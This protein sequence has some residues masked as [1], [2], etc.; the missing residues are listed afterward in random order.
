MESWLEASVVLR[1]T[2]PMPT[3]VGDFQVIT[4]RRQAIVKTSPMTGSRTMVTGK[5]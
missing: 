2:R 3:R 4:V 5:G 1:V